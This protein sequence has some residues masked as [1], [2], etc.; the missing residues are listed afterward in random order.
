MSLGWKSRTH[1]YS[2]KPFN[3]EIYHKIYDAICRIAQCKI[4]QYFS[5]KLVISLLYVFGILWCPKTCLKW[6]ILHTHT[7][8]T[9]LI[10][11]TFNGTERRTST[12]VC[13]IASCDTSRIFRS[14][15]TVR[16][17]THTCCYYT[18]H[19]SKTEKYVSIRQS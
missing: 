6:M 11:E 16:P 1:S 15:M 18:W 14:W 3:Q 9:H 19:V 12:D 10:K 7:H 2:W 17:R 8:S 13:D 4:L 5:V